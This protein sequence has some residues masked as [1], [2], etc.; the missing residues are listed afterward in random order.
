[1]TIKNL[2]QFRSYLV[3]RLKSERITV[4]RLS[5]LSKVPAPTIHRIIYGEVLNP[6]LSTV[7]KIVEA[8]N[9]TLQVHGNQQ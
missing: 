9:E 5:K 2:P 1:M 7:L 6:E 4:Y 8:F 3:S